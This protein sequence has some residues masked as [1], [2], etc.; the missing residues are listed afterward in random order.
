MRLHR[1]N[2]IRS[3]TI[4]VPIH[5]VPTASIC[6]AGQ[7]DRSSGNENGVSGLCPRQRE[8]P[9]DKAE[10]GMELC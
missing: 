5:E 9:G 2:I 3:D 10:S 4:C 8:E 1:F 7:K 6:G